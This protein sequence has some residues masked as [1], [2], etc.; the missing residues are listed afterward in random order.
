MI[1]CHQSPTPKRRATPSWPSGARQHPRPGPP[2]RGGGLVA[3]NHFWSARSR[4][5]E[6]WAWVK[7]GWKKYKKLV[8]WVIHGQ[9]GLKMGNKSTKL[10]HS[11]HEVGPKRAKNV[12]VVSFLWSEVG[13]K[14][15]NLGL[16]TV[17]S[18]LFTV[19]YSL[20]TTHLLYYV[21]YT[22]YCTLLWF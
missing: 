18:V 1:K 16:Y 3:L 10:G 21:Q 17:Y 13:P 5:G 6:G 7:N 4:E 14:K 15:L 12:S 9:K 2:P 20:S 22:V 8:S 19:Y 11:G